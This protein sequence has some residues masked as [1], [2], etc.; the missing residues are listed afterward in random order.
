MKRA[1]VPGPALVQ[2]ASGMARERQTSALRSARA[3]GAPAGGGDGTGMMGTGQD[4]LKVDDRHA[5]CHLGFCDAQLTLTRNWLRRGE[6]CRLAGDRD[7]TGGGDDGHAEVRPPVGCTT[8]SP[9]RPGARA[10]L[11]DAVIWHYGGRSHQA[12]QRRPVIVTG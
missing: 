1:H 6:P 8:P 5:V 9:S 7:S 11:P 4:A 2:R 3:A 12:R 10:P